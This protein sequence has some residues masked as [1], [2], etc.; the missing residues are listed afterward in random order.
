MAKDCVKEILS[1]FSTEEAPAIKEVVERIV[2]RMNKEKAAAFR[3]GILN[4]ESAFREKAM[5][6]L[7]EA[8]TEIKVE[9]LKI[10]ENVEKRQLAQLRINER[11][12]AGQTVENG[13]SAILVS[14]HKLIGAN[15]DSVATRQASAH[16]RLQAA[17]LREVEASGLSDVIQS[18]TLDREIRIEISELNK[19]ED[20]L[21]H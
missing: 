18:G 15:R 17:V 6:L 10:M 8:R 12:A 20:S 9:K 14:D 19:R 11:K 1:K 13:V 2:G 4:P 3:D 7:N 21:M 5:N 16:D